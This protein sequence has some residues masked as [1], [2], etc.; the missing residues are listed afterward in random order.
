ME[1]T[2]KIWNRGKTAAGRTVGGRKES[3]RFVGDRKESSRFVIKA[4]KKEAE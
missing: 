1:G 4:A 2:L 3:G